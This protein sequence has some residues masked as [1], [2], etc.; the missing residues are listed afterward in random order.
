MTNSPR[1]EEPPQ[2][3]VAQVR[4]SLPS[5]VR[6]PHTSANSCRG[7]LTGRAAALVQGKKSHLAN[8]FYGA[9]IDLKQAP[10]DIVTAAKD[11]MKDSGFRAAAP[12]ASTNGH[13]SPSGPH[14]SSTGTPGTEAA[15]ATGSTAS[16]NLPERWAPRTCTQC[17]PHL[18]PVPHVQFYMTYL[19]N[20][21]PDAQQH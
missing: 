6:L 3:A 10:I 13:R 20:L 8:G 1:L 17:S 5:S 16:H 18:H 7:S 9:P 14:A 15:A 4:P 11:A 2:Q 12:V 21:G 19:A